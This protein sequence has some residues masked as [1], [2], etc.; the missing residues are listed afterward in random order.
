MS[1]AAAPIPAGSAPDLSPAPAPPTAPA[2]LRATPGERAV[3]AV[4]AGVAM[5]VLGIAV[6]LHPSSDGIGTHQALGLA[7]CGWV[8]GMSLP[9]PTCGMTTAFAHAVRG[10]LWEAARV[11]PMGMLL[12]VGTASVAV[13]G[14]F[15]ALTGSRV[16]H[17]L[18]A[19]ITPRVV[20]VLA[21][22]ALA[23]WGYKVMAMRG[24][25]PSETGAPVTCAP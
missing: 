20:V 24:A 4:L 13:V 18:G 8:V 11:Q 19:R 6:W 25:W 22:L 2:P 10:S 17:V 9:C 12:A 7:P 23:A 16:G 3:S 21:A 1:S 5:A 14:A 15:V